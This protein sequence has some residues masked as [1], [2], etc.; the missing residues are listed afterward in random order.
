MDIYMNIYL[1][2][3]LYETYTDHY[4]KLI[5]YATRA[6]RSFIKPKWWKY[7][8]ISRF[9]VHDCCLDLMELAI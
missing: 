4:I 9:S 8:V 7:I 5:I 6:E 1:Y 3:Y 2:L